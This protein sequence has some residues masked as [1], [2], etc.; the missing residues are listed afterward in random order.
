MVSFIFANAERK[1]MHRI[2]IGKSTSVGSQSRTESWVVN[3]TWSQHQHVSFVLWQHGAKT[4][5]HDSPISIKEE[6]GATHVNM[7]VSPN[8]PSLWWTTFYLKGDQAK[9]LFSSP[10]KQT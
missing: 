8:S 9:N 2:A 3:P 5:P 7:P 10:V 1:E 4:G 6:E